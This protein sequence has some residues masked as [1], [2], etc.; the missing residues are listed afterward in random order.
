M[1]CLAETVGSPVCARLIFIFGSLK[2]KIDFIHIACESPSGSTFLDAWL[3]ARG[4][5]LA[6]FSRLHQH[7][8]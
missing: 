2:P 8:R 5:R 7:D 4:L 3:R 6:V 1:K